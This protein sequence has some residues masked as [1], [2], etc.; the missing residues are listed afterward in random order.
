MYSISGSRSSQVMTAWRELQQ[1]DPQEAGR[2]LIGLRTEGGERDMEGFGKVIMTN[3]R[4]LENAYVGD[5]VITHWDNHG[6][7]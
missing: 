6:N 4:S 7:K 5:P 3:K 2:L 1:Y